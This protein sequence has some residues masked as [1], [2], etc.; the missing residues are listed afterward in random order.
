VFHTRLAEVT[1]MLRRDSATV[2]EKV[3]AV[4]AG[5]GGGTRIATS[6]A[7]FHGTHVRTG[8]G[9]NARVWVL[10]DGFDADPPDALGRE[11]AAVRARGAA[12]T[13]FHPSARPPASAAIEAAR[14]S[15]GRFVRLDSL[16][17]LAAAAAVLH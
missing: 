15:I 7:D 9:R 10:S 11:L 5:F 12:L 16:R 8:L 3:N 4:S 17:D 2:Q 6:L 13:W 14:A 1:P